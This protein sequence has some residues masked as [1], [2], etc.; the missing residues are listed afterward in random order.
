MRFFH[1]F[2]VDGHG[3]D[4]PCEDGR[5]ILLAV[6][7]RPDKRLLVCGCVWCVRVCVCACVCVCVRADVVCQCVACVS[8][9]V[10]F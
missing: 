8:T 3:H 10:A 2:G 4:G 7:K 1:R 9:S 5:V 6:D